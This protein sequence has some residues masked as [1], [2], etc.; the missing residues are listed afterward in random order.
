MKTHFLLSIQKAF[1]CLA[2]F[3]FSGC[4]KDSAKQ[5]Y[6]ITRPILAKLSEVRSGIKMEGPIS[7]SA[8]GKM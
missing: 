4:L 2:F 1:F 5:S 3:A 6:T 7:V 8:P